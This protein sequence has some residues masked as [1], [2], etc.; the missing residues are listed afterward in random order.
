MYVTSVGVGVIYVQ[1]KAV[2]DGPSR[3]RVRGLHSA[4]THD[5]MLS[6]SSVVG[7][8]AAAAA[9]VADGDDVFQLAI[10]I[11]LLRLKLI[12]RPTR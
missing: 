10:D 12:F 7:A 1:T 2:F 4:V 6:R 9:A 11:A 5:V 3:R 8:V